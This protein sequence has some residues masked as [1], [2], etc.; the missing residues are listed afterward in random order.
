[1]NSHHCSGSCGHERRLSMT[2]RNGYA[3]GLHG[4]HPE[5]PSFRSGEARF[6]D[7][8]DG[9]ERQARPGRPVSLDQVL[10]AR[11]STGF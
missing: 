4:E 7:T 2:V 8:S 5:T 6:R 10:I 9:H 1:M 3:R 11:P